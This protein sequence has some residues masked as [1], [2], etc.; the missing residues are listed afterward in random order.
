MINVTDPV[1]GTIALVVGV[2]TPIAILLTLALVTYSEWERQEI[3]RLN[4]VEAD[5]RARESRQASAVAQG[6]MALYLSAGRIPTGRTAEIL[7]LAQ[8]SHDR[9]TRGGD[10][11]R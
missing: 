11:D 1:W 8:Q 10:D 6:P 4:Q 3:A 5:L 2:F 7:M 9:R